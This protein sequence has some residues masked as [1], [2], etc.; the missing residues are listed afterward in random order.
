MGIKA[1]DE[2]LKKVKDDE[3]IFVLRAQDKLAPNIIRSCGAAMIIKAGWRRTIQVRA[4]ETEEYVL[5]IEKSHD[6][7]NDGDADKAVQELE[8]RLIVLGDALVIERR[9][10]HD[11]N[12]TGREP[13]NPDIDEV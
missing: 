4:Y 13:G 3:P 7:I 6:S 2:T 9:G 10:H 12:A 5:S 8:R 1:T 11:D